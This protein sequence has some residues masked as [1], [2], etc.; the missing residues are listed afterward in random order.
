MSEERIQEIK[1]LDLNALRIEIAMDKSEFLLK[2]MAIS[3]QT[4]MLDEKITIGYNYN[5]SKYDEKPDINSAKK[6]VNNQKTVND[7]D[8]EEA[9]AYLEAIIEATIYQDLDEYMRTL[10]ES[11]KGAGAKSL[12]KFESDN[13]RGLYIENR[14]QFMSDLDLKDEEFESLA[15]AFMG[16][17]KKTKY[18]IIST[19]IIEGNVVATL[20]IEGI[21]DG[22]IYQETEEEVTKIFD[23]ENLSV[24]ELASRNIEVLKEAYKDV[25]ITEPETIQ[26][27]VSESKEGY[28]VLRQD[29][30]LIEGFVQ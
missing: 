11:M 8:K 24:E 14:K 19:E 4:E 22:K 21:N 15:D 30:F 2:N 20:S 7:I 12:G 10:P 1:E 3:M 29:E 23:K 25:E 16:A 17:L 27:N 6:T 18:R 5:Y 26:V 13:F 28:E 9:T